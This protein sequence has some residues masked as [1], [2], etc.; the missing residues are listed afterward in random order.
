MKTVR[1]F[2][3]GIDKL[4][5]VYPEIFDT[6]MFIKDWEAKMIPV[7]KCV[8]IA[9]ALQ[10]RLTI[11]LFEERDLFGNTKEEREAKEGIKGWDI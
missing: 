6:E 7:D 2:M 8:I 5:K 3:E 4:A 11:S 1:E 10:K 9:D